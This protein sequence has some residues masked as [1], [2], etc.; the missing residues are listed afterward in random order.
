MQIDIRF[1]KFADRF[2]R[3]L[4]NPI[5]NRMYNLS[6]HI[7]YLLLRHDCVVVPGLGA[8]INVYSPAYFDRE[9]NYWFPMTREVRFNKAL[10]HDDGLLANSYARKNN[11]CFTDGR[12]LL[13][14]DIDILKNALNE[15]GEVTFGNLGILKN[16]EDTLSFIPQHKPSRMMEMLGFIPAS[17]HSD[18]VHDTK[19]FVN[20]SSLSHNIFQNSE[21]HIES[22]NIKFDT[23]KN[24]YIAINKIFAKAAAGVILL[25][26]IALAIVLP[27]SNRNK[28]DKASVIPVE[29]II[30][31]IV[32]KDTFVIRS[33][34]EVSI[35]CSLENTDDLSSNDE[36]Y[37]A[38]VATFQTIEEAD[39]FISQYGNCGYP[40][41]KINTKTKS[42]VVAM[43]APTRMELY[44]KMHDGNFLNKFNNAWI[45]E[46]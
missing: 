8:F 26:V 22:G 25:A 41:K 31:A 32:E 5:I 34:N 2:Q 23:S 11:I 35:D 46:H 39:R 16:S 40:L 33:N 15:E 19:E 3:L 10:R 43:S 6:L 21:K 18:N 44:N 12:E 37:H 45:W 30:P 36:N 38:V 28:I 29:K 42:R 9:R 7:E 27:I 4:Y 20:A 14:H 17:L 1:C 24:Y 13:R